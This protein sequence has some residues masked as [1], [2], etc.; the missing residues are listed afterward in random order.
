LEFGGVDYISLDLIK[1]N[2]AMNIIRELKSI[3]EALIGGPTISMSFF[4]ARGPL[5]TISALCRLLTKL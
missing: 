4:C 1:K 3:F 2:L 5:D